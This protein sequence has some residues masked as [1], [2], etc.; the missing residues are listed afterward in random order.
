MIRAVPG[1]LK[2][3]VP[4]LV[5]A[6]PGLDLRKGTVVSVAPV[7][8]GGNLAETAIARRYLTTV[9][10]EQGAVPV[11][12]TWLDWDRG[13]GGSLQRGKTVAST[14]VGVVS[15]QSVLFRNQFAR[16]QSA[17]AEGII[18]EI[19]REHVSAWDGRPVPR[20]MMLGLH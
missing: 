9:D 17:C 4:G 3:V 13:K 10:P 15:I 2:D 7:D 8:F 20:G 5:P 16:V 1:T 12:V 19:D 18:V 14:G 6:W 11:L